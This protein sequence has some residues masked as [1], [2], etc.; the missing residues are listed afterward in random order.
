MTIV[1]RDAGSASRSLSDLLHRV[2]ASAEAIRR[3]ASRDGGQ[4]GGQD[5]VA[6]RARKALQVALA[7][8]SAV[9]IAVALG[10]AAELRVAPADDVLERCIALMPR[11]DATLRGLCWLVR[12]RG[13]RR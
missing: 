12:H 10:S 7:S 3:D 11:H 13:R 6:D 2:R 8:G 1:V 4:D 9:E 5:A